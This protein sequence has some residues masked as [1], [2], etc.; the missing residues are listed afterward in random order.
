MLSIRA[1]VALVS[2]G[3]VAAVA[4][5][6]VASAAA[7]KGGGGNPGTP[8]VLADNDYYGCTCYEAVESD[9]KTDANDL[10][11]SYDDEAADDFSVPT[12]TTWTITEV[13]ATF[14]WDSGGAVPATRIN[15]NPTASYASPQDWVVT[16]YNS[17]ADGLPGTAVATQKVAS[18]GYGG[19]MTLVTPVKLA[20]GHWWLSV[21]AETPYLTNGT[22]YWGLSN[23]GLG[24]TLAQWRN[25]GGGYTSCTTWCTVAQPN[26]VFEN[27][28]SFRLIGTSA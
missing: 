22:W 16:I 26:N 10:Y 13:D 19:A 20:A 3:L 6:P 24:G 14:F 23:G 11:S 4:T 18:A 9:T 7:K 27:S 28:T 2:A 15:V 25:P 21:R 1:V 8:K 5:A 12:N 17:G